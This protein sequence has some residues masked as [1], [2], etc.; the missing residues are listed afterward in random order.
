MKNF[1]DMI[2]MYQNTGYWWISVFTMKEKQMHKINVDVESLYFELNNH[3]FRSL[4]RSNRSGWNECL[5]NVYYYYLKARIVKFKVKHTVWASNVCW[6]VTIFYSWKRPGR[7]ILIAWVLTGSHS[8]VLRCGT[9]P[10]T[11]AIC[12]FHMLLC[13][14]MSWFD[15]PPQFKIEHYLL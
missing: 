2:E 15:F 13:V 4:F 6:H 10:F 7:P 11:F 14:L 3:T 5:L 12:N 1:V 8:Y 9:L